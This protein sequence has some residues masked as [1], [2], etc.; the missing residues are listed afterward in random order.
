M[1]AGIGRSYIKR[2]LL[3]LTFSTLSSFCTIR[4]PAWRAANVMPITALRNE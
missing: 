2:L 1:A 4:V 3:W